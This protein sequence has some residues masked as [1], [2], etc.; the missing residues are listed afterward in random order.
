MTRNAFI[1][2][3]QKNAKNLFW[4]SIS[5]VSE[6]STFFG[7]DKESKVYVG[8]VA[9]SPKAE[10]ETTYRV[11]YQYPQ[12]KT[13]DYIPYADRDEARAKFSEMVAI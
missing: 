4:Y 5:N 8:Y 7:M 9:V 6:T 1:K 10:D 12:M 11:Y 3:I 13:P 2:G